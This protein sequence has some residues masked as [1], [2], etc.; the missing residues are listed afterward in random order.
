MV[1]L[2]R[3]YLCRIRHQILHERGV[4]EL[5]LGVVS[6][7]LVK[8][9]AYALRHATLDL[10]LHHQWVD[11]PTAV[12]DDHVFKDFQPERLRVDSYVG[13]MAARRPRRAGRAVVARRLQA[14][15]LT[16]KEGR[17]RTR[18]GGELRSRFG[19]ATKRVPDGIGQHR[20]GGQ[21]N[22][23]IGRALDPDIAPDQL[24]VCGIH[25]QLVSSDSLGLV[26]HHARGNRHR[27]AGGDRATRC[28]GAHPPRES[29][30]VAARHLDI[31]HIHPEL[32]GDD[33]R[34]DRRVGLAL[35]GDAGRGDDLARD[36]HLD[37]GALVRSNPGALHVHPESHA[38]VVAR[39]PGAEIRE[40]LLE[41]SRV[42]AA[43]INDGV[44]ILPGNAHVVR[45]L[46][47]LDEVAPAHRGSVEPER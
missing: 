30:R 42:V 10:A 41:E 47:R 27:I 26:R 36:E 15:L 29:A 37:M 1:D 32:V 5:A 11:D 40:R 23:P 33:L 28:E 3:R 12:V 16:L 39:R 38:N 45:K 6:E 21:W 19:A 31:D 22:G 4:P 13:G 18:P 8:G 43:V 17:S 44:A 9:A 14:R 2:D 34:P 25:F 24:E 7:P 20:D 46:V 35:A